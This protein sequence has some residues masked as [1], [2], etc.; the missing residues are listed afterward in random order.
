MGF[1]QPLVTTTA[2]GQPIML[3]TLMNSCG[4]TVSISTYGGSVV[5]LKTAD[6]HGKAANIVLGYMEPSYY[7]EDHQYF[8]SIV[9]RCANRIAEAKFRLNGKTY[10]LTSNAGR[11]HLHGGA[12]G[13][14]KKI[15]LPQ[16]SN[17]PDGPQLKLQ[18]LSPDMEEGYPGNLKATVIYTLTD[19]NALKIDYFAET[20][21]TTIVNLTHHI[22]FNL[23]GATGDDCLQ[24][25]MMI[26]ADYFL[27]INEEFIPTGEI[28]PV[29][30]TPMDFLKPRPLGSGLNDPYDQILI[31]GGYDHTWVLKEKHEHENRPAAGAYDPGSGRLLELFTTQPGLHFYTGNQLGL[32]KKDNSGHRQYQGFCF[33]A[34]KFPDAPHH[35]DFPSVILAKD[36]AYH[37]TTIYKFSVQ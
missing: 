25:E 13:F 14:N 7:L 17:T 18:Y 29:K 20:D 4:T 30:A 23:G 1:N 5:D 15:W 12:F 28:R 36:A 35:A 22:Y 26:R 8:G 21:H 33:E 37:H 24:Q 16:P 31:A 3:Y 10:Q 19:S 11:H 2:D 32:N 34:Q 27:P 6:R 9:G